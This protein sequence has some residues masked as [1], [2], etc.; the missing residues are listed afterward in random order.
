MEAVAHIL[1]EIFQENR[2]ADKA[3]AYQLK[4]HR[5]WGSRDRAFIAENV[6]ECVRYARLLQEIAEKQAQTLEDWKQI[7]AIHWI[8]QGNILPEGF[9]TNSTEAA[10]L[11]RKKDFDAIRSLRES[12]PEWI[13]REGEQ[14]LGTPLWEETLAFLNKPAEVWLRANLLKT[15]AAELQ[16]SLAKEHIA[17]E[18][19]HQNCLRVTKRKN[20]F[21]TKAF[22]QG[23]FEVQDYGSQQIAPLLGVS[24]GARVIDACAGGGGKTLHLADLM[25]NKGTIIAL[26]VSEKKLQALRKRATRAAIDIVE[27]RPLGNSAKTIKRLHQSADYLLLDVPC[28]G[29]GVLRRN[30]DT[31]W[32]LQE[33]ALPELMTLQQQILQQYSKMLKV[34][35]KMVYAT[36]SILAKENEQQINNFLDSEQGK[37]FSLVEQTTLLPQSH[38]C[39]GFYKAL[40]VRSS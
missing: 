38:N 23:W 28:S 7:W 25:H 3:V 8:L 11:Q 24:A 6:Y 9:A 19:V 30:P 21:Q 26:D 35:G 16:A 4:Q 36:C 40:L 33:S 2:Y 22:Q 15:T 31:K 10:I 1:Q 27:T 34:G 18:I 17:T 37:N 14:S 13:D 12:I 20:L 5:N 39:D 32:K 29:L